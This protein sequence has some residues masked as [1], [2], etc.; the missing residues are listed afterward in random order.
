MKKVVVIT[1]ASS[2]MG[3]DAALRLLEEGY[4]VYGLAR[5]VEKMHNIVAAGGHALPLDMSEE[6]TIP[7][8]VAEIISQQG[9]I[10]VLW[11]NA[12]YAEYGAVED[13]SLE[14]ARRQFEVNLFGLAALTKAVLPTMRVQQAGLIINTSSI[15][16]KIYSPLG[17]WYHASKHALEGW[18]DCLR[19]ELAQFG[20]KVVILEPGAIRTEFIDVMLEPMLE[21]S[22]GSPYQAVVE[23]VAASMKK[24][25]ANPKAASPP[26]VISDTIVKI[27]AAKKPRNRYV[28]GKMARE[29]LFI[30]QWLGDA[31]YDRG[32]KRMMGL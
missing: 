29:A 10:D 23:R 25:Q 18:S 28:V 21:R 3:N 4:C 12:G 7:S 31:M 8:A 26:S 2:G 19:L 11:N 16:G 5:R 9:R 14:A 27:I 1:G 15:G 6:A 20:I 22:Q 30:R 13:V 24:A 32:I 17:A